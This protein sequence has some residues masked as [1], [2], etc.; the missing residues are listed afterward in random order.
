M[1]NA[2]NNN[3]CMT[4]TTITLPYLVIHPYTGVVELVA[5]CCGV[6]S[7]HSLHAAPPLYTGYIFP[8]M[9][10]N[11]CVLKPSLNDLQTFM[12]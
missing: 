3:F 7:P 2:F 12:V 6:S 8:E 10:E 1:E 4:M 5:N 9:Q 11:L